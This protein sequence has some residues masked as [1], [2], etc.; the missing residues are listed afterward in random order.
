MDPRRF[1]ELSRSLAG[2]SRRRLLKAF[3]GG[4]AAALGGAL[5]PGPAGANPPPKHCKYQGYNC[6]DNTNCCSLNCCNRTCC[7]NGQAC[8]N[9]QCVWACPEGQTLNA[10]CVCEGSSTPACGSAAECPQPSAPCQMA[11]CLGGACGF[12][13]RTNG[14]P[15]DDGDAC[16]TGSTCQNGSCA[17][18]TAVVCDDGN[19]CTENLCDPVSGCFHPPANGR[20]CD[21]GS[22]CVTGSTCSGGAC[23]GG[24]PISCDDGNPCT[25]DSCAGGTCFHDADAGA[26]CTLVGGAPG[27]C[28]ELAACVECLTAEQ[29][30]GTDTACQ[31]RVCNAGVCEIENL[32][33]EAR[34]CGVGACLRTVQSCVNG[35]PQECVP[36]LPTA[37]ACN[38]ID[39]DCDGDIDED[40][41]FQTDPNN[42]G[43]C[44]EICVLPNATPVCN[45]GQCA[46]ESCDSGYA[47]CDGNPENGC[48]TQL[49]TLDNCASCGDACNWD[50]DVC[51][52]PGTGGDPNSGCCAHIYSVCD[53]S[54][55]IDRCCNMSTCTGANA[56]GQ[57]VC[58]G[59]SLVSHCSVGSQC[60]SGACDTRTSLCF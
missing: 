42:C 18:G 26:T 46:I 53:P 7:G 45:S 39:D 29:C 43:G 17:G 27:I 25:V 58:C 22:G 9:G 49:G 4:V 31:R 14:V 20:P 19:L 2:T 56:S 51:S 11:V 21:D 35:Q 38:G 50:T 34:T 60:C 15:C 36:G 40:W 48:E 23:T 55:P 57:F 6:R 5:P 32:P 54:E 37:E 30:P 44:G 28:N 10:A 12:A 3:A 13:N 8:C 52:G 41:D 1:D 59:V 24:T 16:T 47:D 33:G